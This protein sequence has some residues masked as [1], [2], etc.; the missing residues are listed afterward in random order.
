MRIHSSMLDGVILLNYVS[1]LFIFIDQEE[2]ELSVS[3]GEL[4]RV[5]EQGED[6]WWTAEKNGKTGLVPGNYLGKS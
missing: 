3:R 2:D 4:I 6:G 1:S 5:L